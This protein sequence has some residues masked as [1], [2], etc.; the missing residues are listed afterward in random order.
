MQSILKILFS[1]CFLFL[2]AACK[3]DNYSL[4][5]ETQTGAGTFGCK[6]DGKVWVPNGSDGYS[7]QNTK[8]FYQFIYP[9]PVGYVFSIGAAKYDND[10]L[11]SVQV[12][13]DSIKLFQGITV[14]L[15]SGKLG[16]SGK[17]IFSK[18]S[19]INSI[20]IKYKTSSIMK[21]ELTFTRFDEVNLVA[22]GTFWFDAIDPQGN[23]VHVT[24]GRFDK[25]F[26][27]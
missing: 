25:K 8:C 14:P 21:G 19:S 12:S 26:T 16:E 1:C 3:K 7:G 9:S 10:P 4:P 20:D 15:G 27:R 22:S 24:E 5:P 13:T 18:L 11:E 23:V 6:I 2:L 17:G